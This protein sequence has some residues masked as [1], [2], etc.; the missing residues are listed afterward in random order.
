MK[1]FVKA[2]NANRHDLDCIVVDSGESIRVDPFVGCAVPTPNDDYAE[3][4]ASL[5]GKEF[6]MTD[7]HLAGGGTYL[8]GEG[9]FKPY[10]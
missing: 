4:G 1:V 10:N 3:I 5:V 9:C 6:E 2:Y 7:Y 8:M